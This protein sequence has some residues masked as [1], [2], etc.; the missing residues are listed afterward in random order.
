[1]HKRECREGGC[2][3]VGGGG[4]REYRGMGVRECRECL[5]GRSETCNVIKYYLIQISDF[6][7]S[8]RGQTKSSTGK[9]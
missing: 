1:M 3:S 5:I 8:N 7:R 9:T 6:Q 4:V 2:G